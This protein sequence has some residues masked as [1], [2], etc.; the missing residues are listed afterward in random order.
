MQAG[1]FFNIITTAIV[2][3]GFMLIDSQFKIAAGMILAG[4]ILFMINFAL[5]IGPLVWLYVPEIVQPK[6][7]TIATFFNWVGATLIMFLFPIIKGKILHGNPALLFY[8]FSAWSIIALLVNQ[9][10]IV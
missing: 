1:T 6:I 7:V 3:T 5:T 10:F 9:K 2:G 8:F 4:L